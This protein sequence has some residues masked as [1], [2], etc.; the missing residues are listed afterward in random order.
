MEWAIDC[1][2]IERAIV[3]SEIKLDAIPVDAQHT[4][5]RT[6]HGARHKVIGALALA[7]NDMHGCPPESL[8]DLRT[9]WSNAVVQQATKLKERGLRPGT[10]AVDVLQARSISLAAACVIAAACDI[11]IFFVRESVAVGGQWGSDDTP[12]MVF[13]HI[14]GPNYA[15]VST[16]VDTC[17]ASKIVV[18]NVEKPMRAISSYSAKELRGMCTR[19]P[20]PTAAPNKRAAYDAVSAH[21]S[22]ALRHTGRTNPRRE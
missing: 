10:V 8:L 4:T 14:G 7:W 13:Q 18:T 17:L 16:C 5:T 19:L 2:F 15:Q 21:I 11:S 9:R 12:P 1:A 22:R 20:D 6:P 3:G